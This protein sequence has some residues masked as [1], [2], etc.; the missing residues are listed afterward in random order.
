MKKTKGVK[1]GA[2]YGRV[3]VDEAAEVQHG[4]LEQQAHM[5]REQAEILSKSMGIPHLIKHE[6]IE[7]RGVSGKN[8]KRPKYQELLDLIRSQQI[9]FVVAKEISRLSR[10]TRDFCDFLNI[11]KQH[12]V[13]VY[14]H[15]LQADPNNPMGEMIF[16][17]FA[18]IAE[19]ERQQIVERT[20]SSIRSAMR[21]N[22]KINGGSIPLGLDRDKERPGFWKP[23]PD[24]L[25]NV[26]VL[27]KKFCETLSYKE[28]LRSAQAEGIKNKNGS[29]FDKSSLKRLLTNPKYIGK[30]RVPTDTGEEVWVD[31][32]FGTIVSRDLFDRAQQAVQRVEAQGRNKNRNINRIY[33]LSGL[34]SY[35]DGSSMKGISGTSRNGNIHYYYR[36]EQNKFSVD[37]AGLEK[38][39]TQ[40]LRM[41][42]NNEK[43]IGY[44]NEIRRE[45]CSRV[46]FLEQQIRKAKA[47]LT[48]IDTEEKGLT[49]KINAVSSESPQRVMEW[50]NGQLLDLDKRRQETK[51][52]MAQMERERSLLADK[53]SD[54]KSLAR[55]LKIVF[56]KLEDS[57]PEVQR[58]IF[59]QLFKRITLHRDNQVRI[60]W[61]VP[62]C[63][64]G[65]A[66]VF[67]GENW[68][69]RRGLN[70][71]QP[72]SQSDALP[73]ELRP[74]QNRYKNRYL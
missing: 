52:G 64:T 11:C 55:S 33:L 58:G 17:I 9:D 4:S 70:P 47:E 65:G 43:M 48:R 31:L 46:D 53:Y 12:E 13:A 32:P 71:R 30:L 41:F 68:G 23:N 56:D 63:D 36:N 21:N 51:L 40:S 74:P 7:E 45:T 28:T 22:K 27:M 8:T 3:S 72:E 14:I 6:L 57:P 62:S 24:E 25:R 44:A 60:E 59:R 2:V 20:K 67:S 26:E 54:A 35:E 39:V 69:D 42:E 38:A 29:P 34:L 16:K 61:N 10:S 49:E 66:L 73:T 1:I 15:G 37:A 18:M 5:G 50:I 19:F